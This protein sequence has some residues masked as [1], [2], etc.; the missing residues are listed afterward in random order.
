MAVNFTQLVEI[1]L[2]SNIIKDKDIIT[3]NEFKFDTKISFFSN[4]NLIKKNALILSYSVSGIIKHA[5]GLQRNFNVFLFRFLNMFPLYYHQIFYDKL[6]I[7]TFKIIKERKLI[8]EIVFKTNKKF[9]HSI[10]Y[11]NMMINKK[12]VKKRLQKINNNIYGISAPF[13]TKVNH[14]P[15]SNNLIRNSFIIAKKI[16]K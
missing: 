8:K 10:H 2:N 4:L 15:I 11:F 13:L 6:Y 7:A 3:L 1:L 9:G 16:N 12:S 5:L 14:G